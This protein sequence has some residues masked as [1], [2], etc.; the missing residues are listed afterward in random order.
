VKRRWLVLGAVSLMFFFISSAT[1][2]SLGLVLPSM[3]A[4]LKWSQT[5]AGAT[6]SVLGLACCLASLLPM[7]LVRRIGTRWTMLLGAL[8][9][10]AGFLL[11]F[12]TKG[13]V[14]FLIGTGLMGVGFALCANIP[15]VYLLAR[16]FPEKSARIIG[17]YFMCGAAGGVVGPP[18]AADLVASMDWRSWWMILAITATIMGFV[19]LT[20]V[21]DRPLAEDAAGEPIQE[22]GPDAENWPYKEA[23]RTPQFALLAA[24]MVIT[25]ACVTVMHSAAA[26]HFKMLDH[27]AAFAAGML[28]LQ[29]LFAAVAKGL[30][31]TVGER[32]HPRFLLVGGLALEAV[33]FLV[34]AIAATPLLVG[35]FAVTFGIG[36][37]TAYLAI[38]V[39]MIRYFGPRTGSDGMSLVWLLT[40]FASLAPAGAGMVADALGSFGP[41][42]VAGALMLAPI[43]VGMLIVREPV[44]KSLQASAGGSAPTAVA[45]GLA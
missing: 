31:G 34:L 1:F 32:I 11:G 22:S 9:L 30:S 12:I 42:F 2:M 41:A 40:V 13:L 36:W 39:L 4:E 27:T 8:M 10:A 45:E 14:L 44:R 5:E 35:V 24:A 25:Q 18:L 37:G 43:A 16:W 6:F 19:C 28:G 15:G 7:M 3:M 17:I 21:R 29:A 38:T 20:I 33:G 26:I 23:M